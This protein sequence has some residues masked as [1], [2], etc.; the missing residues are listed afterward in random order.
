MTEF[1]M[2]L[3]SDISTT[4][5]AKIKKDSKLKRIANKVRDGTDYEIAS[6]YSI[7]VGELLSESIQENTKSLAYMSREVAEEVLPP[8][9]T[10]DHNMVTEVT[11]IIQQNM[12][13]ADGVMLGVQ[14]PALDTNRI[15]GFVEKVASYSDF[16]GARWVLGEP[17]V[18]YSQSIV[19]QAVRDNAKAS[20][21]AG[22]QA[23]IVRKAE[24]SATV[25]RG[26]RKYHIPC[27][28]CSALEGTYEYLGNGS[29]IPHEVYQKHEA[30]RCTL[31]FKR[32]NF[33]QNVWDHRETWTE[34]DV[35]QQ[36]KLTK[37]EEKRLK[38][39]AEQK[40][41]ERSELKLREIGFDYVSDDLWKKAD[42]NLLNANIDRLGE[43]DDKFG[44]IKRAK[45]PMFLWDGRTS[46]IA[47]VRS[48]NEDFSLNELAI[49][50][51]YKN[52]DEFVEDTKR[53]VR[54]NWSM[55][56][57]LDNQYEV[58]TYSITHEYGH[59]MHN[60][61]YQQLKNTGKTLTRDE[62]V[63]NIVREI[64]EDT[65]VDRPYELLSDYGKKNCYEA[66]AEMFANSQG[67]K[68]NALGLSMRKW[69]ERNAL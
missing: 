38:K 34:N 25:T 27:K 58:M 21:K 49:G 66:F 46:S 39:E 11:D 23:Y 43:L 22:V 57:D 12:N 64:F 63:S 13:V 45:K 68:P 7:R 8:L 55:P 48:Y 61:M 19:D 4:F 54:I 60:V 3:L 50:K 16:D 42:R 47:Y 52:L 56:I 2:G 65:G 6:D 26:R 41:L 14:T 31:T 40:E 37:A 51:Y 59:M 35:K 62:Y 44:I 5:N 20:A 69:L 18:N 53:W 24:A 10:V 15:S 32:G 28:W 9:L 17:I 1:G 30:C 29:N 67:S 36:R 33:R